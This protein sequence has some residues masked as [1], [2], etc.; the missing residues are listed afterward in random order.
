MQI[1]FKWI[2]GATW[3]LN[4][5]D[6]KIACDPVLCPKGHIQNYKY[7]KTTRLNDP[8]FNRS[9][10]KDVNIWLL[11]HNHEDHIDEF[12]LKIINNE[13]IIVAHRNLKSGFNN[14]MYRNI[15]YLGWNEQ[16]TYSINDIILKIRSIPAIHAKKKFI[17]SKIGNGNGYILEIIKHK[18][19][20]NIYV[21]GDSVYSKSVKKYFNKIDLDLIIAN[22]GSAMAG[23]SFIS[24]VIGRITNNTG[25]LIKLNS[26]LNSKALIPVHWGTFSHYTE[27]IDKDSFKEYKNIRFMNVGESITL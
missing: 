20:Y 13:S 8:V 1:N 2:G 17:S 4:I 21:T 9:D 18:L 23:R 24:Y 15:K 14:D 11:T 3:I 6:I 22:A 26:A 25:D 7:F 10:F 27:I 5:D 12:G 16:T 19:K